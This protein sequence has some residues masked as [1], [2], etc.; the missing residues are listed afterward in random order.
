GD[1]RFFAIV[2]VFLFV[3]MCAGQGCLEVHDY[4]VEARVD[5]AI[6]F[7]GVGTNT[8]PRELTWDFFP[9]T[10]GIG[11]SPFILRVDGETYGLAF[12]GSEGSFIPPITSTLEPYHDAGFPS[13][14]AASNTIHNKWNLPDDIIVNQYFTP[15]SLDS[16]GLI[17]VRYVIS[18]D[19]DFDHTI[20]LEHKWDVCVNG[21]DDAPIASP[22]S[23]YVDTNSVFTPADMP[24]YILIPNDPATP[25]L[26]GVMVVDAFDAAC[27][28]FFAFGQEEELIASNFSLDSTF[29]G[30][31]Y[32][33]SAALIRWDDVVVPSGG[34]LELITYY[35]IGLDYASIA[36]TPSRPSDISISAYPNPFNSA[37]TI[38]LDGVGVSDTP[39]RLEIYDV[40]GRRMAHAPFGSAQGAEFRSLNEVESTDRRQFVWQPHESI[41]SGVYLVRV[42]IGGERGFDPEGSSAKL[43]R[44]DNSVHSITK[45][46]VYMK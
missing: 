20:A 15:D 39:L 9:V 17:K 43:S 4:G 33:L 19:D 8:P 31:S 28:D 25:T 13:L 5:A 45:R 44:R 23:P 16:L 29:A 22:A 34:D 12:E 37:V 18:N 42:E 7:F 1:M 21:S 27:P 3:G 32:S 10:S 36:E 38:T 6:G 30:P 35:G 41:P 2:S 11:N 40:S 26:V 24:P 46:V 14:I